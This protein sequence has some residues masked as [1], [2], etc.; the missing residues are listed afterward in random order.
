MTGNAIDSRILNSLR[1]GSRRKN[2][3]GTKTA[4]QRNDCRARHAASVSPSE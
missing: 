1:N 3:F 4:R 2:H